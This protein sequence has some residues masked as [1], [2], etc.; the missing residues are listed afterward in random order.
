MAA[1]AENEGMTAGASSV[2]MARAG[3]NKGM[4]NSRI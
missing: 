1:K 4:E 2:L 3:E